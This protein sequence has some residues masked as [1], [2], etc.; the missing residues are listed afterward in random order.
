MGSLAGLLVI[1]GWFLGFGSGLSALW[2]VS[3]FTANANNN[4]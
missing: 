1:C 4:K 3:K 2:V